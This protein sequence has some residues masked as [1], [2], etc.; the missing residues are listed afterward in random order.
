M[1]GFDEVYPTYPTYP[2]SQ[3][4]LANVML[5]RPDASSRDSRS[6]LETLEVPITRWEN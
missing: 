3:G 6:G 5:E 2:V 1:Q 4:L